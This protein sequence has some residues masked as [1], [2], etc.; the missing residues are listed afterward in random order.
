MDNHTVRTLNSGTSV[1]VHNVT[2]KV[3]FRTCYWLVR[4][5]SGHP[6]PDSFADTFVD[7]ECGA[8]V[9]NDRELCDGHQAQ[10]DAPFGDWHDIPRL[11]ETDLSHVY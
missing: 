5:P 9:A 10:C 7:V 11:P 8:R 3:T 4:R 2:G 6:E 1:F